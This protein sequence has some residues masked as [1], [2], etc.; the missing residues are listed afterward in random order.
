MGI[1]KQTMTGTTG[2]ATAGETPPVAAPQQHILTVEHLAYIALFVLSV[3]TRLWLLGDRSLHHDETLHAFYSWK[4]YDGQ[5]Y[6]HDPLMHGPL[7]YYIGALMYFLFSDNDF[8]ARLGFALFGSVLPVLPYLV[9]RIIGSPAA[10]IASAY[11][12]ISPVVLYIGRFARHDI[13]S[14]TFEMLIFVGIARYA[15]SRQA[16]WLYLAVASFGLMFVN[17]ETSY[18]FVLI[19]GAPLVLV[20]LWHTFKPAI[21]VLAAMAVV[22]AACVF[23]LPGEPQIGSGG[24]VVRD[25]ET[26]AIQTKE[27][28]PVFDWPPL[29]TADNT[30]A[31]QIRNRADDYLGKSLFA[32]LTEYLGK[33]WVFFHHPAI[34]TAMFVSLLGLLALIWLIWVQPVAQGK[35]A[36]ESALARGNPV[37]EVYHSLTQGWRWLM[38]IGLFVAIYLLFFTALFTN[39]I[40]SITGVVG[41]LLYWLAQHEVERGG[42][43]MHYYGVILAVY[44]PLAL[45]WAALGLVLVA[46]RWVRYVGVVRECRR[47]DAPVPLTDTPAGAPGSS[48]EPHLYTVTFL[49]WWAIAAIGIYSWAG[50]KM[51]WLS[52]HLVLPLTLLGA[53][54]VQWVFFVL[55]GGAWKTRPYR[56]LTIS[57]VGIFATVA[58]LIYVVLNSLETINEKAG[59]SG[60]VIVLLIAVLFLM[61]LIAAGVN[62][63]WRWAF[64]M[65]AL[66]GTLL[67]TGYTIRS[68]YRLAYQN[69]DIPR[70]MLIYTQTSPDVMRIMRRLEEASIRRTGGLDIPVIYDNETIWQWYLRDFTHATRTGPEMRGPPGEEVQVVFLLKSNYDT[71]PQNR[72]YLED[73]RIHRFPLRWWLPEDSVYRLH[74]R[75]EWR[76]DPL[77]QVSLLGRVLRAPLRDETLLDVWDFLLYRDTQ[78]PLGSADFIVAVRPGLADQLGPGIGAE[79]M[80]PVEEE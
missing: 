58:G 20:L 36:W 70:E 62:W 35:T 72:E 18:L 40:G 30:F 17:Q 44:E 47:Q 64:V 60:F 69:G 33:V 77:E 32:N 4:I 68:S 45:V 10:L 71:Y 29:E 23:V 41:S 42:Q 43:P 1:F 34:F 3:L 9:R 80:L 6:I 55:D 8:T 22:V 49:A 65:L 37:V 46:A 25:P 61:L 66:C 26:N 53:Y 50:E 67:G 51:P 75:G 54:A 52:L 73:F 38:A 57:A 15:T 2:Y 78:A 11:M 27:P 24:S 56:I 14:V 7:L 76:T 63:G 39:L 5:G 21:A 13:Y 12:V 59:V 48:P 74:R 19:V 79:L 28:G 16:R 31:L